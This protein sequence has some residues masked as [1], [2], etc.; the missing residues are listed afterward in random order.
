MT[1]PELHWLVRPKTIKA[2]WIVFAAILA[3]T[4]VAEA[5]LPIKGHFGADNF[6]GFNAVYGFGVCVV[7]VVVAKALGFFLKRP[8]NYY[9]D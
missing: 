6:L 9:D 7:M 3:L 4:V 5:F 1:E 8:D 2:L